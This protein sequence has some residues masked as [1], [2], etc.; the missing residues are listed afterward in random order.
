M[1]TSTE[2]ISKFLSSYPKSEAA[3]E[4]LSSFTGVWSELLL[5]DISDPMRPR[6]KNNCCELNSRHPECMTGIDFD[7]Q[8][9][10]YW[11]TVPTLSSHACHFVAREQMNGASGYLDGSDI[12]GNNDDRL[13]KLRIYNR[14]RVDLNACELCSRT[15]SS[16]G[17]LYRSILAE[18]NRIADILAELNEFWDDT[19]LYLEARRAVVAQVRRI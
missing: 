6:H 2:I 13:H 5:R 7:G 12:Y 11:R 17:N 10:D 3:H 1:P 16:I 9:L 18:H 19:R 14:G 15:N 8:C 4:G